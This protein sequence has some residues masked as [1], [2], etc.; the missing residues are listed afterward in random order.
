MHFSY[1]F[2][3]VSAFLYCGFLFPLCL[4]LCI[5]SIYAFCMWFVGYL[6]DIIDFTIA[7]KLRL[8][9]CVIAK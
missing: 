8:V 7:M 2:C 1:P 4:F 5:L 6:A 9:F 3:P